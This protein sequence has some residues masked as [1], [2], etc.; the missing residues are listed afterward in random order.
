MSRTRI[1]FTLFTAASLLLAGAVATDAWSQAKK[2]Q[3]TYTLKGGPLGAVKFD[4]KKHAETNKVACETCHHASKPQKPATEPQLACNNCHVTP[5]KPPMKT[6]K[7]MAFHNPAG[8][9]GTCIDCH[10]KE[11]AAGKAAPTKCVDCHKKG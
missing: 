10:K 1:L 2:A 7:M 5:Q 8:N 9:A 4:H 11:S 3:D 6:N